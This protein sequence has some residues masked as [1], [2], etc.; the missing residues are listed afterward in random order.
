M[1][2]SSFDDNSF[3]SGEISVRSTLTTSFTNL[4]YADN[5]R[6]PTTASRSEA[7]RS[8]SRTTIDND[9]D[10]I[11]QISN[12]TMDS[13]QVEDVETGSGSRTKHTPP[14][15]K[16]IY[17]KPRC[18]FV[19]Y[20]TLT[21][22]LGAILMLLILAECQYMSDVNDINFWMFLPYMKNDNDDI[23][24]IAEVCTIAAVSLYC[25]FCSQ[26]RHR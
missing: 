10:T 21:N 24:E 5:C 15:L 26:N 3:I 1:E 20:K 17:R 6:C 16:L 19:A 13:T 2:H 18:F 7:G 22:W 9:L 25:A 8:E 12:Q 23:V 14:S 4:D 11:S